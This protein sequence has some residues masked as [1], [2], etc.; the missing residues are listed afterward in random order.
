MPALDN[1]P[2]HVTDGDQR[3]F[4]FST[5]LLTVSV[6]RSLYLLHPFPPKDRL[7]TIMKKESEIL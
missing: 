5:G 1:R 3:R 6:T 2:H 4:Y 7:I